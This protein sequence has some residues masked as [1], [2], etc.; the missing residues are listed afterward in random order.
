MAINVITLNGKKVFEV[1]LNG[2]NAEGKRIQMRKRGIDSQRKAE[3]IE[4]EMKRELAKIREQ[5]VV[6]RWSE[7]WEKCASQMRAIYRPS[8]IINYTSCVENWIL[9]EWKETAINQISKFD[10]HTLIF[11]TLPSQ[12][13]SPT[14]QKYTLKILKRVFEMAVD[15]GYLN[16][17]PAQG[18]TV[19]LPEVVQKVLT[20]T[21]T[22]ILLRNAK[23][24][25]HRFYPVWLLALFT[26]CRS[27]ELYAL[28]WSDVDLENC[29]ISV[30]KSW[31]SK[32]GLMPTKNQRNRVV[33]VSHELL[34][35]LRKLKAE[36]LGGKY[37]LPRLSE[38]ERG[39]AAKVLKDFCKSLG[40]TEVKF[41][42]L[43][44]TFITNLL[45]RGESLV[46]VMAM[47]GHSDMETTNIYLRKAGIE[48]DGGT[49]K[50]SFKVPEDSGGKMLVFS[51]KS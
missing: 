16:R 36:R 20:S 50:L 37:V 28:E 18:I 22:D 23:L 17:N 38:W 30:S 26:G 33:P 35:F 43:R 1:Y 15:E 42:D 47:V 41:H 6:P 39:E 27:G 9:P 4:F 13:A 29:R 44:A 7:W 19:K 8:T 34:G 12:K 24:V 3:A 11:K 32:N 21:E 25:N 40:I 31:S 10:I 5:S 14:M 45:A 46:R 2:F 51:P 48:L 49:D